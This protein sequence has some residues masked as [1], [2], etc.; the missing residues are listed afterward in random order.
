MPSRGP[1]VLVF[2]RALPRTVARGSNTLAVALDAAPDFEAAID[3]LEASLTTPEGRDAA[4]RLFTPASAPA[5][6]FLNTVRAMRASQ[7]MGARLAAQRATKLLMSALA[8]HAQVGRKAV[9]LSDADREHMVQ[10]RAFWLAAVQ[11]A[12]EAYADERGNIV[13]A[14]APAAAGRRLELPTVYQRELRRR[15]VAPKARPVDLANLLTAWECAV[16]VRH[17]RLA[18]RRPSTT[19]THA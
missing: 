12:W 3:L 7:T 6:R 18:V 17:V 14:L 9:R 16:P 11:V 4:V 10:V 13:T 2:D 5:R 1:E 8:G 15:A 19:V